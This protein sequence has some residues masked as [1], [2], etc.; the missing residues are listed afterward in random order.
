MAAFARTSAALAMTAALL[1]ATPVS[2]SV[3]PVPTVDA[4]AAPRY[5]AAATATLLA[6]V[7][8]HRAEVGLPTLRTHDGLAAVAR[9]H[10]VWMATTGRLEHDLGGLFTPAT[11]AALHI[12]VFAEN[13]A[14]SSLSVERDHRNLMASPPHR[15][16]IDNGAYTVAGFAVVVDAK[17]WYWATET[18]GT[19]PVATVAAAPRV[20]P[21]VVRR[22]TAVPRPP[23]VRRGAETARRATSIRAERGARRAAAAR[24]TRRAERARAVA[25]RAAL[26]ELTFAGYATRPRSAEAVPVS[27]SA[28]AWPAWLAVAL[29]ALVSGAVLRSARLGR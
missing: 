2:A 10:T 6:L 11:H 18:F 5:D 7:N 27:P 25:A 9:A 13:V 21:A 19:P 16:N 12:K 3:G 4:V 1:A 24:S 29:L 23:A 8:A 15:A 22:P 28:P 14:F 26:P 20:A 17:G